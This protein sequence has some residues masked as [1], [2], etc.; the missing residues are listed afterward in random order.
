MK[1]AVTAYFNKGIYEQDSAIYKTFSQ[2]LPPDRSTM[3]SI[4]STISVNILSINKS[5]N[6]ATVQIKL[7]QLD[8][9]QI[10]RNYLFEI[11]NNA[12]HYQTTKQKLTLFNSLYTTSE[13]PTQRT[14]WELIVRNNNGRWT[15][16]PSQGLISAL[17]GGIPAEAERY[18]T[19]QKM[20]RKVIHADASSA[21]ELLEAYAFASEELVGKSIMT[22]YNHFTNVAPNNDIKSVIKNYDN[23]MKKLI[24]YSKIINTLEKKK[25][26][27]F[28]FIWSQIELEATTLQD[29]ITSQINNLNN[30]GTFNPNLMQL[31]WFIGQFHELSDSNKLDLTHI[32]NE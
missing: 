24:S 21:H 3:K 22:I 7:A 30:G 5:N 13:K 12:E 19:E 2:V 11:S 32:H 31:K 16:S 27:H 14:N 9:H 10:M 17:L 29:E 4:L 1:Q 15:I 26:D 20:M 8:S 18:K 28:Q 25:Y 6:E 23:N